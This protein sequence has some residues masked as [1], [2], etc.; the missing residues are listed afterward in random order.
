MIYLWLHISVFIVHLFSSSIYHIWTW[1]SVRFPLRHETYIKF[2]LDANRICSICKM[3]INNNNK[4]TLWRF[5]SY[6]ITSDILWIMDFCVSRDVR[7]WNVIT[8]SFPSKH[9]GID[10]GKRRQE[11]DK[12]TPTKKHP[13]HERKT[14]VKE[15]TTTEKKPY[16]SRWMQCCFP[17]ANSEWKWKWNITQRE[18]I[19][20]YRIHFSYA[21]H[22]R[23]RL[24]CCS[25]NSKRRKDNK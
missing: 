20:I 4:K 11:W 5:V 13:C 22:H 1:I 15:Q 2:I 16:S 24:L 6:G 8:E 21:F 7:H 19:F 18:I 12:N 17:Q 14:E 3:S 23:I 25:R 10:R 9:T